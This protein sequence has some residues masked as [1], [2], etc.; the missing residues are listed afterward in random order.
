M[1]IAD[2]AGQVRLG[3][4]DADERWSLG[5]V[6]DLVGGRVTG[7]HVDEEERLNLAFHTGVR[8]VAEAGR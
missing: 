4:G 3:H 6:L 1:E 2:P 8:V 5:L 7:A